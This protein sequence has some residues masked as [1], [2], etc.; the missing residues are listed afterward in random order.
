MLNPP[1]RR[2]RQRN[3]QQQTIVWYVS[4]LLRQ[5]RCP[6]LEET[7]KV[8]LRPPQPESRVRTVPNRSRKER[9]GDTTPQGESR[10]KRRN[11]PQ[12]GWSTIHNTT[13]LRW[14][15]RVARMEE[16]TRHQRVSFG[17][18]RKNVT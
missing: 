14:L 15:I 16:S 9:H 17:C 12:P 5:S 18:T 4:P 8:T 10:A 13:T 7:T 6:C 3:G 2:S 1:L 11:N